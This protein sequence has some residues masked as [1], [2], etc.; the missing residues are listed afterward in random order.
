MQYWTIFYWGWWIAWSPFVGMFIARISKGRT[1][2]EVFNYSMTAPLIY[3]IIWFSIFGGAGIKMH[4]TAMECKNQETLGIQGAAGTNFAEEYRSAVCCP[5]TTDFRSTGAWEI[6]QLTGTYDDVAAPAG[7]VDVRMCDY[8]RPAGKRTAL[9]AVPA[10]S[11]MSQAQKDYVGSANFE[12]TNDDSRRVVYEHSYASA[13]FFETLEQYYGW[14]DFLTGT[15]IVT[16]IL[17]FVTS[18]DS[19]SFVVD[20]ISAGGNLD[21]DGNERDPHWAQRVTWS[22]TEGGLAIGLMYAGGTDG[23]SAL[24]AMSIAVGLPFTIVLCLMIPSLLRML[25]MEVRMALDFILPTLLGV[26]SSHTSREPRFPWCPTCLL[27]GACNPMV[28]P[29]PVFRMATPR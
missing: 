28:C 10:N 16:I 27:I 17:Y 18:S 26:P 6:L 12:I 19:G 14:G 24:R 3:V 21:K 13:N 29:V 11:N 15:T 1:I 5:V 8:L 20:L 9:T 2:R 25:E 22:L 4:N 7:I 23:T